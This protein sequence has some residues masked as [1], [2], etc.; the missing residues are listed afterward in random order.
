MK[1]KL[2]G[3]YIF[4]AASLF[5]LGG[6]CSKF[7]GWSGMTLNGARC[8]LS[9]IPIGLY[10]IITKHK[11]R[12][13]LKNIFGGVCLC[14]TALLC[15]IANKTTTAA[16]A[17][18]LQYIAPVYVILYRR[19]FKKIRS[20]LTDILT[21]AVVLIGLVVFL[22]DSLS[23]GGMFGNI[24]AVLSGI[25]YATFCI[26]GGDGDTDNMTMI[27][28]G[29][30]L[31]AIIGMPFM[32]FETD[33]SLISVGTALILGFF[34]MGLA[35]ILFGIGLERTG[36]VTTSLISTVEPILNPILVA[37]LYKEMMGTA[38]IIGAAIVIAAILAYNIITG[39]KKEPKKA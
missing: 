3:L 1:N 24:M 18:I 17:I 29:F 36:A 12:F 16:N 31:G 10:L 33:F 8:F 22:S 39:R 28:V 15:M 32:A 38:A 35:Y 7:N 14:V 27:L 13:N 21:C 25:A 30:S 23:V 19:V 6:V 20:G 2:G 5:S 34:Q 11:L 9:L 4:I 37:L 26:L